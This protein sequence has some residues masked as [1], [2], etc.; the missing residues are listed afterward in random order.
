[1]DIIKEISTIKDNYANGTITILDGLTHSQ[2]QIIQKIEFYSNSQYLNGMYD[3]FNRYKPFYNIV[4]F[5]VNVAVKATDLD[6]KDIQVYSE[7]PLH[8][9]H[10]MIF[11][12]EIKNW[13]RKNYFSKTLNKIGFTRAKYGGVIVKRVVK[14]D[15]VTTDIPEWK[16]LITDQVDI[17]NGTKI[18]KHYLTPVQI[19]KKKGVWNK[20]DENWEEIQKVFEG[21]DNGNYTSSSRVCI[22]EVEGEF[23]REYLDSEDT[24]EY[25]L[26]HYFILADANEEP[27]CVLHQ[28]EVT[29]SQYKY[30][31]WLEASGRG[32]G[33]GI[34]EDGFNAQFSTN[35]M[36]LK[37]RD[38]L[39]LATKTIIATDSDTVENNALTDMQVGDFLKMEKGDQANVL[40]LMPSSFP[41]LEGIKQA[42]DEQYS[43]VSSSFEAV[44]GETMPS[45]TPFRSIAIQNQEAQSTFNYRREEMGI[46]LNE[47]FT[48]WIIP[49]ISKKLNKKHLLTAD[50]EDDELALIDNAFTIYTAKQFVIDQLLNGKVVTQEEFR[51]MVEAQKQLLTSSL[52]KKR[53]I[54]IPDGFFKDVELKLDIITTGEQVNKTVMFETISNMIAVIAS[55]PAVLQDPVLKK[56]L[57]KA[58]ELSG[59]GINIDSLMAQ[60]P[61]QSQNTPQIEPQGST[62]ALQVPTDTVEQPIQA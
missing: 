52:K 29:T 58:I 44:T 17:K 26:Q 40:N 23:E 11:S 45:G 39:E 30:L 49:S 3:E 27:I 10:S 31:S 15:E 12:K 21:L 60:V 43:R 22:Y 33:I 55:N 4:N 9:V 8:Q 13:M 35:D 41:Q 50:F 62:G 14:N 2:S 37:Q 20:I 47:I 5:R 53:Y 57:V 56:L 16:N 59:I 28:E 32:I 42:W 19:Q 18:E 6:T 54:D 51:D 48:D 1:M 7:N 38:I 61:N 36:V 46:F 34:V 25:S 24:E